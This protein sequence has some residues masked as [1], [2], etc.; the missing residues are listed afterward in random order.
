MPDPEFE[1]D[2]LLQSTITNCQQISQL[3]EVKKL[4]T[5]HKIIIG[6]VLFFI[7][8]LL[9]MFFLR[10]PLLRYAIE[11]KAG[12]AGKKIGAD[13]AWKDTYF[14]GVST[15]HVR[16]L[17]LTPTGSDTLLQVNQISIRIKPLDLLLLR[18]RFS[19]I[20]ISGPRISLKR[21]GE[22][23]NYLF[24]LDR[25][26]ADST[27]S[28]TDENV[29]KDYA[30]RVSKLFNMVFTYIP[31]YITIDKFMVDADINNHTFS[32][33]FPELTISDNAFSTVA[34]VT[35]DSLSMRWQLAGTLN[36]SDRKVAI[37][38][39]KSDSGKVYIPYIF[40]RWKT[41]MAFDS[42]SLRLNFST[43]GTGT[44]HLNGRAYIYNALLNN[45][46]IS[47]ND[48]KLERSEITYQLNFGKS[49]IE[50]D[51]ST[52]VSF[53]KIGFNPYFRYETNP[54]KSVT[55]RI[56]EPDFD[57]QD[58]FGSLPEGLF[59]NLEGIKVRGKLS[60]NL[61]F[62]YAFRQPDSL[63]FNAALQ[64]KGFRVERFG[65]TNFTSMNAPFLYTAYERGQPV[66]QFMVGPENKDFRTIDQIPAYLKYAVMTSEDGSFYGH[67]GF[68]PDA[69]RAAIITNIKEKRFARGGSTISMQLVKNVFLNRNKT[70]TRKVEEM[71]ITWLIESQGMVSKDRMFE[72][73]LNIIETG[74][75]VYGVNEAARFYFK[76][77]VAKLTLAES[78]Y[79]ASIIPRPKW[80]RYSFDKTGALR[81]YL[82]SY[83]S[84]VSGKMLR[85]EWITQEEYDKLRPEVELKGPAKGMVLPADSIPG[86]ED[87]DW[88]IPVD[89]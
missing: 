25:K 40:Q 7:A 43:S 77:D 64:S 67:R 33:S 29:V 57:A 70:I 4:K 88:E 62:E 44:S 86:E 81:D 84:L 5:S 39:N 83:Y 56:H 18:L 11:K 19:N 38:V 52:L 9:A 60:F 65:N 74:P 6:I 8:L 12:Q 55:F 59:T 46:R 89:L 76:K 47:P 58:F 16:G 24:L 21:N 26:S 72:V 75:M 27:L 37:E 73:Y 51:S 82:Q 34:T 63:L 50:L 20:E 45:Y 71:L 36:T 32:F 14:S 66:R 35:D 53:N 68:I 1:K 41:K 23:S 31:S 78:I 28:V 2:V 17:S 42:A 15:I 80:F 3:S 48:V 22:K 10:N 54:E 61:D 79:L 30:S 13:I 87:P 69:I 85:K 49:Y